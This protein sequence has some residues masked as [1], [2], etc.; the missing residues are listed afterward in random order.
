MAKKKPGKKAVPP[1]KGK[2]VANKG[3]KGKGGGGGGG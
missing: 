1:A 3:T 2:K